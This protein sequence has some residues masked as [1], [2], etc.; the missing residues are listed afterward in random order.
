MHLDGVW[1]P[2]RRHRA[3]VANRAF[4]AGGL[5]AAP[6]RE[7]AAAVFEI[8]STDVLRDAVAEP[9]DVALAEHVF[10]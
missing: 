7:A 3:A 10:G 8:H 2:P 6:T 9:P 5:A 1:S 4:D